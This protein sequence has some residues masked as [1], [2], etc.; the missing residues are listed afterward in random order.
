VLLELAR[1][2]PQNPERQITLVFF[3]LEDQGN[4]PGWDWIMGSQAYA[5]S[6]E[7]K[8]DAV[9]IVDMVGDKDLNI[10]LEQSSTQQLAQ[11]IWKTANKNGYKGFIPE[12]KY[13][14]LDDHTPFL[15]IGIPAVDI[16]DFDYPAW[17]TISDTTDK[18]SADSLE[19]VGRTLQ[20]WLEMP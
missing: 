17:H 16:I 8:P 3:D 13:S 11:T 4:L 12:L 15:N 9:V 1:V 14:M 20:L 19:Q 7:Q 2:L 5:E 10:Y 18:V 6:L